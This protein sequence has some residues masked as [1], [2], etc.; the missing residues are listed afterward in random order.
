MV[1]HGFHLLNWPI[2]N[3][4]DRAKVF[5]VIS[6]TDK[7]QQIALSVHES[8]LRQNSDLVGS[9]TGAELRRCGLAVV[10]VVRKKLRATKILGHVTLFFVSV[11]HF[12]A[13]LYR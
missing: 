4:H 12:H 10:P 6:E 8:L 2:P 13:F 9:R 11:G 7:L 1:T 5:L 3:L